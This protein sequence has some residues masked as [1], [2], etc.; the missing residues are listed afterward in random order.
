MAAENLYLHNRIVSDSDRW[1]AHENT[2]THTLMHA[3]QR[4]DRE[5]NY[6]LV[7]YKCIVKEFL[8]VLC[9]IIFNLL[10]EEVLGFVFFAVECYKGKLWLLLDIKLRYDLSVY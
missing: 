6:L 9:T 5:G 1:R 3:H 2:G 8:S 7:M 10:G 4:I